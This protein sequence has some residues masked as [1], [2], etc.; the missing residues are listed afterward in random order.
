[1][2]EN[3]LLLTTLVGWCL[4]QCVQVILLN[5]MTFNLDIWYLDHI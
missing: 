1:M 4:Y 3:F 5:Q 2:T